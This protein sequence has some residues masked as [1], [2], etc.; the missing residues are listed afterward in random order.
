MHRLHNANSGICKRSMEAFVT[1]ARYRLLS[2]GLQEIIL[3]KQFPLI[4][5]H[6][7]YQAIFFGIFFCRD[8]EPP[9]SQEP[10]D[11]KFSHSS[12][13]DGLTKYMFH[14]YPLE[15]PS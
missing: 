7:S 3:S 11:L 1:R 4:E 5:L 8:T 14:I 12:T 9:L 10:S 13:S 6:P 2:I 15:A